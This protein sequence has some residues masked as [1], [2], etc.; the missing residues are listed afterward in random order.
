MFTAGSETCSAINHLLGNSCFAAAL[1]SDLSKR[2][3]APITLLWFQPYF[4]S[5]DS[6]L[7]LFFKCSYP[8]SSPKGKIYICADSIVHLY[9]AA[10]TLCAAARCHLQSAQCMWWC[11]LCGHVA[12][13]LLGKTWGRMTQ[14][15]CLSGQME[16]FS[17]RLTK[18][19]SLGR[20]WSSHHPKKGSEPEPPHL[21][22]SS[23]RCCPLQARY[24]TRLMGF[25]SRVIFSFRRNR[26]NMQEDKNLFQSVLVLFF[27][28]RC[29]HSFPYIIVPGGDVGP[30]HPSRTQVCFLLLSILCTPRAAPSWL[31]ARQGFK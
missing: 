10:L 1:G 30:S 3:A 19:A 31:L 15:A 28:V 13:P 4:S 14:G 24:S 29:S 25:F 27:S 16:H 2:W 5:F 22:K 20:V 9:F 12:L 26:E 11:H 8:G 21:K 23:D 18:A 7:H 17:L 6:F